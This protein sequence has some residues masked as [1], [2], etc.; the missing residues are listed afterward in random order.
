MMR[1]FLLR[2]SVAFVGLA[3]AMT[4]WALVMSVL[5]AFIGL[6]VFFFG[7]ALMQSQA[8]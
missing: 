4:G 5:L 6:P 7:L 8:G 3:V 1:R 2:L